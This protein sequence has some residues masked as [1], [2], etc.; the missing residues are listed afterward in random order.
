MTQKKHPPS[1]KRLKKARSE[2]QVPRSRIFSAA[3]N[4][5]AF[6]AISYGCLPQGYL[7]FR[8]WS[9]SIWGGATTSPADN[10]FSGIASAGY[11]LLPLGGAAI[12]S[13]VAVSW[14]TD[15]LHWI[16][17]SLVPRWD[18]IDLF[19]GVS[20]LVNTKKVLDL[21]KG[22]VLAL[23]MGGVIWI[24]WLEAL[25]QMLVR[26]DRPGAYR[27]LVPTCWR[28]T[29]L[30]LVLGIF[31]LIWMRWRHLNDLGMTDQEVK[32]EH[33]EGQGD[34][35]M[36]SSRRQQQRQLLEKGVARGTRH[37]TVVI[38][39][40]T[41]LAVGLRYDTMECETPYLVTKGQ[42]ADAKVIREEASRLNIPIIKDVPLARSLIHF[43]VGEVIPEELYQAVAAVLKVAVEVSND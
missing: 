13:S 1:A 25:P 6:L 7:K 10:I 30:L 24:G 17:V 4:F 23:L 12:A 43:D 9:E 26:P 41:H 32:Q 19:S 5:S 28:I 42:E 29:L 31:D 15:G 20:R 33:R 14:V 16:P 36:K 22:L 38:V 37:A 8:S 2:G 40:P 18:R 3:V 21:L 34:P 39:N 11:C 27:W 35:R